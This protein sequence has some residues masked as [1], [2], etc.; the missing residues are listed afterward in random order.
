MKQ[1]LME[2]DLAIVMVIQ[3]VILKPKV[4]EM[5]WRSD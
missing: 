1:T 4:I 5:D 3:T 2:I